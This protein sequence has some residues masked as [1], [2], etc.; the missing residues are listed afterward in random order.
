LVLRVVSCSS[1]EGVEDLERRQMM[2][3]FGIHRAFRADAVFLGWQQTPAGKAFAIYNIILE[4]HPSYHSTV[5]ESTLRKL[6][7]RIPPTPEPPSWDSRTLVM[8]INK[9][10][11]SARR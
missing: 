2:K 9:D 11:V 3:S 7:L 6:G 8:S 4:N 10:A 5:T 1:D